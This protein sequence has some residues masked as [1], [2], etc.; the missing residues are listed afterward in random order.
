MPLAMTIVNRPFSRHSCSAAL[1]HSPSLRPCSW[2]RHGG[3]LRDAV[4]VHVCDGETDDALER[5][6]LTL[7]SPDRI[8]DEHRISRRS[9]T[10]PGSERDREL[11][12]GTRDRF[13]ELGLERRRDH[14][15]RSPAAVARGSR[16]RDDGAAGRGARRCARSRSPA[17]RY[18][19]ISAGGGRASLSRLLRVR[20]SHRAG[21]LRGQR[22]SVP[23]TIALARRGIDIRGKIALVRYSVPYS[24]RGFKALTAQQRGAAGDPDLFRSRR[25]TASGKGEVYPEGPWGPPSHIQ[26]GGIV[27][28]FMVPGDPLDARLGVRARRAPHLAIRSGC[29]ASEHHQRAAVVSRTRA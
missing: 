8:R 20:R 3:S 11:A 19:Q 27:Y 13:R 22:Q 16:R 24:Y 6:F 2:R 1:A 4:R 7:P 23:T 9:R 10:S 29:L 14:D 5:R 17:I 21:R 28:D 26:R 18:T 25:T 15:A 12:D